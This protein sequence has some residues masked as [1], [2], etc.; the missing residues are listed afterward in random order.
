MYKDRLLFSLKYFGLKHFKWYKM[1]ANVGRSQ[2]SRRNKMDVRSLRG[3]F[4]CGLAAARTSS[5]AVQ[6]QQKYCL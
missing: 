5:V 4:G 1:E 3:N 6:L 2:S